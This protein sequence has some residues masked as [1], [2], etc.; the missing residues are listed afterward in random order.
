MDSINKVKDGIRSFIDRGHYPQALQ[1]LEQYEKKRPEDPDVFSLKAM[2]YV[3]KGDVDTAIEVLISGIQ[4]NPKDFDMRYNLAYLYEQKGKL[5]KSFD[6][7]NDSKDIAKSTEQLIS[8]ENAL[9]KL[10]HT[11]KIAVE[12]NQTH[13]P[14]EK[15]IP[16]GI[17][18]VR[19]KTK[20]VD[21]EINKCSDIF[22]FGFGDDDWHPFVE[23]LKEYKEC[24]NLKYQES[25]LGR[26]YQLFR[27]ENLQDAIGGENG[28]K[29]P[30][31]Q[32]WSPLP[33]SVHSNKCYLEN[34]KQKKTVDQQNYF[35]GPNSNQNGKIEMKKLI[36]YYKLIN[37]TGYHPDVFAADGISGYM[38]K[39]K[40]EYRFVVTSGHHFVATLAVLGY[41]SIRCQLPMTKDQSKVVDIK[42]INKWPQLQKKIY[43][44]ETAT[45]FFYSFFKDM[46]RKKAIESDILCK[47]ITAREQ[48][49][50][51]KYDID[52][53]NRHNVKFYNAG[54][55]KDIDEDYV[56]EVQQYWQKHYGKTIDPGQ[57]IAHA[58]LTGQK[59]P[60]VIPHN[61]MWGEFIPF[62]NDTMMGKVGYSD[63]NIYDKLIPAPNRAVNVLKRVRGKYFD[64]DNNYLGSEEAFRLLKSQSKDLIIKPSTTD[65]GKG[66]AKLNI[67]G[68]NVYHKGKIIDISDIEKIWGVNFLVQESIQQHSVLAEPHSSSV[69]TLRMVTLR[70]KGEVHNLLAYA[71]FGVAGQVQD[72]SGAGG[73]CCGITETG[74]FMDYAIDKKANIYTHHPT[75]NYCFKDYAK[76]PNY[77]KCKK[78]VRDLHKEVLHCDLVSWDVVVGTDCEPIFLELNFWG[79]TFLYQINCQTPLFGDLTGEVLKHVR[80]N[81]GK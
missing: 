80:D 46:G 41:K 65:D 61:I 76:V 2:I 16:Y 9:K 74:E 8:V 56:Q 45:R 60:R 67:K 71:R 73:V 68:S 52:I 5:I 27:P 38:L 36:D 63:K 6:T 78:L 32:G 12:G 11:I 50:F 39:N 75:T 28:I 72:N 48:E 20:L 18:N 69:N 66:I 4:N 15:N 14:D 3:G 49:Q 55:L 24:P 23:L 30:A 42:E 64:A 10:K 54:L 22:A 7:Y 29:A 58:N 33:W 25:V 81:R 44:K 62:F 57:H 19:S 1:I 35:F 13:S 34:K 59:D 47:D 51:S 79:P 77:D 43:N 21:V 17:K 26:F 70:W 31:S 37:D 53:K 40:N